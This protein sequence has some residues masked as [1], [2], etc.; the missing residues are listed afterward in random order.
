[1]LRLRAILGASRIL[2]VDPSVAVRM[3]A[4]FA[5]LMILAGLFGLG[6]GI[7][8]ISGFFVVACRDADAKAQQCDEG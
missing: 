4:V 5:S 1:M 3:F 8:R 2:I 6:I 7:A